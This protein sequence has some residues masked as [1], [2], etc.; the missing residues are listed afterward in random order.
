MNEN[1]PKKKTIRLEEIIKKE[2]SSSLF[3]SGFPSNTH[4]YDLNTAY[5]RFRMPRKEASFLL[6]ANEFFRN[7]N[8]VQGLIFVN[9]YLE[10]G[11]NYRFWWMKLGNRDFYEQERRDLECKLK[12]KY[13]YLMGA[14]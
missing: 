7:L 6:K 8:F 2:Y 12:D 4:V 14:S 11:N 13:G 5:L 1:E 3:H 9:D 10:K